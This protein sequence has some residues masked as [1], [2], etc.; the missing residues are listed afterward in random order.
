MKKTKKISRFDVDFKTRLEQKRTAK[1]T[2]QK[3]SLGLFLYRVYEIEHAKGMP[4]KVLDGA[5]GFRGSSKL[6]HRKSRQTGLSQW[7]KAV[8]DLSHVMDSLQFQQYEVMWL[9][10]KQATALRLKGHTVKPTTADDESTIGQKMG[11]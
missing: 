2:A 11:A 3:R 9:K 4:N 1:M 7:Q 8:M 6:L 10:P 5:Y